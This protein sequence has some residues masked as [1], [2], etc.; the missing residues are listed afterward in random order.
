M[1]R[2]NGNAQQS[3]LEYMPIGGGPLQRAPLE[4]GRLTIGR[5][6]SADLQI[7]STR[8]SREH[9][10]VEIDGAAVVLRDLGSTN[11]TFVNGEPVD[12]VELRDGDV[13]TVAD[14]DVTFLTNAT[15]RLRR[16]ATQPLPAGDGKVREQRSMGQNTRSSLR[17][18]RD[19]IFAV[20]TA[21]ERLMLQA[22]P[23]QL[24]PVVDVAAKRAVA[25]F[26]SRWQNLGGEDAAA[27]YAAPPS[28]AAMRQQQMQRTVAV[29]QA[30]HQP[31]CSQLVLPVETWEI[32]ECQS[33]LW[34]LEELYL[35]APADIRLTVAVNA[36]DAVDLDAAERFCRN[37]KAARF[38]LALWNFVGGAPHVARL[39][40]VDPEMLFLASEVTND[41]SNNARLRRQLPMI[42]DACHET[43]ISPVVCDAPDRE[44]IDCLTDDGFRLFLDTANGAADVLEYSVARDAAFATSR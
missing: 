13:I 20:R 26:A 4:G 38:G 24:V 10:C 34:H 36:N 32:S 44:T 6:E 27:R 9:A 21:H 39:E 15:N 19:A 25:H 11:G 22:A 42:V 23:V 35:A 12:Q 16:M 29:Q 41:L 28:H 17:A 40:A 5:C 1:G 3:W 7:D 2:D 8:V 33:V 30:E 31:I 18:E 37:V 43:N 14:I